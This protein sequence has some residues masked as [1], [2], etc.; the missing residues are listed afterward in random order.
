L[1]DSCGFEEF[2]KLSKIYR[3]REEKTKWVGT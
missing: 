3:E 2:E 1:G